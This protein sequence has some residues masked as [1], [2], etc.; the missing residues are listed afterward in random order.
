[1]KLSLERYGVKVTVDTDHDDLTLDDVIDNLV[2]PLLCA[3]G[4]HHNSIMEWFD[5]DDKAGNDDWQAGPI[6]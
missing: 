4:F 6:E 2:K 3:A 5:L 1:M